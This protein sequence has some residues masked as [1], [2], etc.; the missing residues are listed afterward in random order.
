[1]D[2]LDRTS[3]AEQAAEAI[4]RYILTHHLRTGDRLPS[5]RQLGE[6]LGISRRALRKAHSILVGQGI[7]TKVPGKGVF[8]RDFDRRTLGVD[9][10]L[11]ITDEAQLGALRDLRQMLEIGALEFI[12]QRITPEELDHL[13]QLVETM[14]RRLANGERTNEL[15]TEFHLTLFKAARVPALAQM[16][17]QVLRD[18]V[19]LTVFNPTW[20][21]INTTEITAA[22]VSLLRTVLAAL[23]C[24]DIYRAQQAMKAHINVSPRE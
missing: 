10:R 15:D 22:N 13:E 4:K 14:E 19:D 16:Y 21:R 18:V 1:M 17:E 11:I 20:R 8:I 12:T 9:I 6:N 2:A 7:V 24:G 3:L 23:R 5:E